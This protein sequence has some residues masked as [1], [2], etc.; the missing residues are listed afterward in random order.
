MEFC[1]LPHHAKLANRRLLRVT[2]RIFFSLSALAANLLAASGAVA[3]PPAHDSTP[4]FLSSVI[5]HVI[6][7]AD[8]SS[9]AQSGDVAAA[10]SSLTFGQLVPMWLVATFLAIAV[11]VR[12]RQRL[13]LRC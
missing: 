6:S 3:S 11:I 7:A 10:H 4:R 2:A 1:D 5:P 12:R 8:H 13:L 9:G